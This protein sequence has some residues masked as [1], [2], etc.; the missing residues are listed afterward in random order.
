MEETTLDPMKCPT[1]PCKCGRAGRV[2]PETGKPFPHRIGAS[3]PKFKGMGKTK[4]RD[5]W[6][7]EA[8]EA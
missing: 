6:C 8:G 5:M 1:M 3:H 4:R 7:P 2:H